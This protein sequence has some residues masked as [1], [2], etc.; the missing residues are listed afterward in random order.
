MR[1]RYAQQLT[2]GGGEGVAAAAREL[3]KVLAEPA[4]TGGQ[5]AMVGGKPT[6]LESNVYIEG[7]PFTYRLTSSGLQSRQRDNPIYLLFI[8]MIP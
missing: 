3:Q 4:E 8:T 6:G 1:V 7:I 2:A 5:V